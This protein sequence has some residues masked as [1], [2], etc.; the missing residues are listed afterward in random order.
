MLKIN[1]S[2][3]LHK[4]YDSYKKRKTIQKGKP[5][6]QHIRIKYQISVTI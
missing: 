1:Q 6:N 2:G 4:E 5:S 3:I